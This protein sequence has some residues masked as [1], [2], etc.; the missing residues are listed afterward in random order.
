MSPVRVVH[1]PNHRGFK[2]TH[3]LLDAVARLQAEGQ[4]VELQLVERVPNRQA[5]EIYRT[6]DIVF[7]QCLIGFHGYFALEALALG[8]PVMV[9]IRDPNRYL[10]RPGECPFVNAPAD[11]VEA[12]LR[13]L[14]R[15]RQRLHDLGK[16]GRRYIERYFSLEAYA[17]RLRRTYRELGFAA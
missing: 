17:N 12:V 7:D 5:L 8:K 2:G 15:D 14:V 16:Q 13:E 1:A 11:Q 9:F 10:L 6:A 3:Y 4:P